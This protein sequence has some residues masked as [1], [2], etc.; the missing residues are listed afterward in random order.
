MILKYGSYA[1]ALGEATIVITV[2]PL[3]NEQRAHY[4]NRERWEIA[5]FLQAATPQ[6]LTAAINT[7]Q[8]AYGLPDQSLALYLSDGVTLTSHAISAADT[9]DGVRVV[10]GPNF[11]QGRGA[12]YST[13]RSYQIIVEA[14]RPLASA[15]PDPYSALLAWEETIVLSGG[16]QRFV[17]LQT[18]YGLPQKQLVAAATPFRATQQGRA[19]GLFVYPLAPPPIW[20]AAEHIDQRKVSRKSPRSFDQER[21]SSEFETTWTY[22]FE[23]E[24]PLIGNPTIQ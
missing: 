6:A 7:M 8:A 21:G 4:A 22:S 14:D 24:A 11:P 1:H 16:G 15:D 23:S 5:G 12:E 3:F 9:L 2:T 13:F 18:L 19:I 17:Y 20:P 10:S